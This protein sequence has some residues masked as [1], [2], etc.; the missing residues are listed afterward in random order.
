[1]RSDK[2]QLRYFYMKFQDLKSF[3]N[4]DIFILLVDDSQK[5]KLSRKKI[6]DL[7]ESENVLF[8]NEYYMIS[9]EKKIKI[10]PFLGSSLDELEV[11][12][13]INNDEAYLDNDYPL[14]IILLDKNNLKQE[15]K[16]ESDSSK[17][18][19]DDKDLN[20]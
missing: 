14:I 10:S 13:I 11:I 12:K 2:F 20:K 7:E 6:K 16:K 17:K 1:M 15:I 3:V 5:D 4:G 9:N 19:K 18:R 8:D